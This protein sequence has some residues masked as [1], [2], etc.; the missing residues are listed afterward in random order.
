MKNQRNEYLFEHMLKITKSMS[1]KVDAS[2][3]SI[4]EHLQSHREWANVT[5]IKNQAIVTRQDDD[6]VGLLQDKGIREVAEAKE[7]SDELATFIDTNLAVNMLT[8]AAKR[9]DPQFQAHMQLVMSRFGDYKAGPIK[10][11]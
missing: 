11:V 7:D 9:L 10:R 3:N 8:T 4:F 1:E 2:M 5:A 6:R